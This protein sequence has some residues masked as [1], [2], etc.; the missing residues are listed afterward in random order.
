MRKI[1]EPID[2]EKYP[3][4]VVDV[5]RAFNP[6]RMK[7]MHG[8]MTVENKKN[9]V[10]MESMHRSLTRKSAEREKKTFFFFFLESSKNFDFVP[11][12]GEKKF[13]GNFSLERNRHPSDK[14]DKACNN[15]GNAPVRIQRHR[16]SRIK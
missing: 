9:L 11:D 13:C 10:S 4:Q 14:I 15:D 3:I 16:K 8:T 5:E 1:D 2:E 7:L 12:Y 6:D